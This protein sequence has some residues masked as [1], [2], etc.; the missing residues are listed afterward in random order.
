LLDGGAEAVDETHE[1]ETPGNGVRLVRSQ[2][3]VLPGDDGTPQYI[4]SVVED[5]TESARA[6]ERIRYMAHHDLL[7][8]LCNRVLFMDKVAEAIQ[9]LG[10]RDDAFAIFM[11]DLDRFKEVNDSL[12][13]AA[14][15]ELLKEA[16]QRLKDAVGETD[17]LARLGG[18]E[19]AVIQGKT[20]DPAGAARTLAEHIIEIFAE[21]FDVCGNNVT[22]GVS[23]GISLAPIDGNEPTDLMKK[24]D[25]AL[26]RA[27]SEGR[28]T[29]SFF[30]A[31]LATDAEMR[32]HLERDLRAA[33]FCDELEVH[34]QPIIDATT[35]RTLAVEALAR[36]HHPQKGFVAPAQFIPLA[37]E[38]GLVV[39]LGEMIL[40]KACAA[41]AAW[42]AEIKVAVNLSPLQ[43]KKSSLVE[44]VTCALTEA[45]LSPERLELEITENVL[46]DAP[47]DV[48]RT[49][50]QL[51]T[52]GVSIVLDDFG[53]GY[54]SL[55]YLTMFPFDKIKIDKSFTQNLTRRTECAAIVSAVRALAYS[56]NITVV[57]EGVETE[58]QFELLRAAGIN[59]VQGYLFAKP[60]P[61]AA[62]RLE[63]D[64]AWNADNTVRKRA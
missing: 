18:D 52:L 33:M 37:E 27:K 2:K 5:V 54:S 55:S 14:G 46:I 48:L 50:R 10:R 6:D 20:T 47:L 16:A 57:A 35:G 39:P 53:T 40:Q 61:L 21:P 24:A 23:I 4:L 30:D 42:P 32:H 15:D 11:L 9:S 60:C 36:W 19:F 41:A 3:I 44:V 22:V 58:D 29:H 13:H 26:Y 7:T 31:R 45:G 28:N 43:F 8:G 63:G 25:L 12:G 51:K 59:A 1:V 56:L 38:T 34:Y 17:V 64:G 62:L 49:I